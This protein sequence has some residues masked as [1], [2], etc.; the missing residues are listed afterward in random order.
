MR[1]SKRML[2]TITICSPAVRPCIPNADPAIH[3]PDTR[4]VVQKQ[5]IL[6]PEVAGNW[7]VLL[8]IFSQIL[9]EGRLLPNA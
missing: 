8:R 3:A 5:T 1:S 7:L 6:E 4:K 2:Q 9:H